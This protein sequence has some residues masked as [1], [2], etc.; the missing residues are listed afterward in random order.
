[1][2]RSLSYEGWDRGDDGLQPERT[3][4]AWRRT[5]V[6]GVVATVLTGKLFVECGAS[7]FLSLLTTLLL[8]VTALIALGA[9]RTRGQGAGGV[10]L[11]A[12]CASV[13]CS[14]VLC[15]AGIAP[16]LLGSLK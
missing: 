13:T 12:C 5:A 3:A 11:Y 8:S 16:H 4:L 10:R 15:L 14:G 9:R 1:M 7:P 6:A 2:S